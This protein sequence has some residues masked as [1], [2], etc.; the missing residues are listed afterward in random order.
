MKAAERI[1]IVPASFA[2]AEALAESLREGDA[3]EIAALGFAPLEC[4]DAVLCASVQAHAALVADAEGR[5]E[6]AALWGYA[7]PSLLGDTADLW[8]FSGRPADAYPLPFLKASRDFVLALQG[9]YRRLQALVALDYGA[10]VRWLRWLG[11]ADGAI[12]TYGGRNFMRVS[13]EGTADGR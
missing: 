2:H 13:R 12:E 9:R 7:A 1:A 11:F 3:M 4:L 8:A 5:A 10:A 6:V